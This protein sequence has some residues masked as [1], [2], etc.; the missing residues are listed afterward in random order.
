MKNIPFILFALFIIS[1]TKSQESLLA[2]IQAFEK[3]EKTGT[4]EGLEELS[5]LHKNY[6]LKYSDIEANNYL[7]AAAQYYYYENDTAE[8]ICYLNT[9]HE[10][11]VLTAIEM[12]LSI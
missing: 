12:Q 1:C 6:G 9:L 3:S 11:I 10:T 5:K 7:Y 2:E 4:Q 8:S